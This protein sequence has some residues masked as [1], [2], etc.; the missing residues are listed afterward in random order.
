MFWVPM[1]IGAGLGLMKGMSD[2][3]QYE[4]RQ[5]AQAEMTK[6]SPWTGM[7]GQVLKQPN[8]FGSILQGGAMGAMAGQS[9]GAG[10]GAAAAPQSQPVAMNY[11][12]QQTSMYYG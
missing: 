2:Q 4:E 12:P 9:M 8:V 7:H 5:S 1:A 11:Q 6:Y 10:G 3:K